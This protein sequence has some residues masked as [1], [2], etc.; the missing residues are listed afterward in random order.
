ML[1]ISKWFF[2]KRYLITLL[3][4]LILLWIIIFSWFI[5]EENKY[6]DDVVDKSSFARSYYEIE[7]NG[8]KIK[9]YYA[10][11]FTD[12]IYF[13]STMFGTFGYGDI[14]PKTNSAKGL[15][16]CMHFIVIIFIMGLYE[17]I[18]VSN[19]TIK[20]LSLNIMKLSSE[21]PISNSI[22]KSRNYR[23]IS[24]PSFSNVNL[25]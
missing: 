20:D 8:K 4:V 9:K 18:F 11:A 19:K 25:T 23:A 5:Y 12:S 14:Y 3:I 21:L 24:D 17:N 6:K 1:N 2:G 15:I 13:I 7:N 22:S 16:T 10:N